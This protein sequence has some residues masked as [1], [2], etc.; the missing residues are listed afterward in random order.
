[1]CCNLY[2]PAQTCQIHTYTYTYTYTNLCTYTYQCT[3]SYIC[4]YTYTYTIIHIQELTE[5]ASS[6]LGSGRLHTNRMDSA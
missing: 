2:T 1:M 3:Y 6:T 4:R 5:L